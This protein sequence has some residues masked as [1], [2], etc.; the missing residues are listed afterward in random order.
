MGEEIEKT[1]KRRARN[2]I[3]GKTEIIDN[4][5]YKDWY[6]KQVKKYGKNAVDNTYKMVKNKANDQKQYEKY[7]GV[8]GSKNLPDTLEKW[9]DLKYNNIEEYNLTKYNY[10]LRN[11]T[12]YNPENIVN[13]ISVAPEKY[14]KYLFDGN[15]E[16]GLI[17]GRLID[18]VLGF[19]KDNY[20][21]FDKLIKE[22]ISSFPKRYRGADEYGETYEVNMVLKGL[23]DRQAKVTVGVKKTDDK[24]KLT[25]VYIEKLKRAD[26]KY[27]KHK[28]D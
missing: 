8:I 11:E 6:D 27:E 4:I 13:D 7:K 9:Q 10:K 17:K 1:L 2:P 16:K 28:R 24:Y 22:N 19:N 26:L 14:T 18:K 25:S 5:S 3:T 15:N 23:K 21:D 20:M 12:K